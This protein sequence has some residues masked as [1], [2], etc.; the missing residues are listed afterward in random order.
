MR[1]SINARAS[2]A[3]GIYVGGPRIGNPD[4]GLFY[5]LGTTRAAAP[6]RASAPGYSKDATH[7]SRP[8]LRVRDADRLPHGGGHGMWPDVSAALPIDPLLPEI[9]SVLARTNRLVLRAEPGAGKTTRVPGALLD[10][11]VAGRR[12]VAVVEPRR[13][14]A[15][16]SAEFV[17]RAR[18]TTVGGDVGYRVRFARRGGPGTRLWFLTD[19]VFGRDL[20]RDPFLE[21]VGVVV[22]DEFHE[23]HLQSDLALAVVRELQETVRPD[24]RLVVMSATLET[25]A[26][27]RYLGGC[28]VITSEGRPHPVAIH[29]DEGG[30][31]HTLADRVA[32]AVRGALEQ[33]GDVLVFLPG[34]AEIRRAAAAL[35]PIAATARV[36][37]LVLHGD[38]PLDEQ[39]RA[40]RVGPRRRVV[41]ATNVAETALTVEGVATVVDSGLARTLRFDARTGLDHLRLGSI[42]RSAAT[43]RAGR[44]GRLG[45]GGCIRLWTRAEE[46]GRRE[47]EAPEI[48]RVDLARTLLELAAWGLR[49]VTRLGWLDPPPAPALARAGELLLELGALDATGAPTETGRRML[50]HPVAPRLARMLV[51]AEDDGVAADGALLAALAAER[52]VLRA[53]RAFGGG[54]DDRP[55]GPSDLLARM[56]LFEE[57]ARVGFG[58]Q[59]CLRLGLDPGAVRA[60][61]R[62]RRQ[63][64]RGAAPRATVGPDD[65]A[66]LARL[67]RCVL[68]GFPDRV[69]RRREPGSPRAVMAGGTGVTLAPESVVRAAELFVAVAVEGGSRGAESRV[70]IASAVERGWLDQ[71][72]PGSV[73][74]ER[75]VS[76]DGERGRV[77]AR[78]TVRYRDVTLDEAVRGDVTREEV[79]R[80]LAEAAERDARGLLGPRP[81]VDALV[82]R[83][84]FLSRAMPELGL[85][86]DVES[87]VRAAATALASAAASLDALRQADVPGAIAGLLTHRQRSAVDR[88][89]PSHWTLPS[90]RRVPVAYERDRAPSARGRIQEM[91]G[92]AATPRL[93]GGRVPLVLALLAPNQRPVQ[94]TDDLASFWRTTYAQVRAELRGRYPRHVW[95]DDPMTATPTSRARRR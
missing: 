81:D 92:L 95:P 75:T 20:V 43:Q 5:K 67:L 16:A 9:A 66:S 42:S 54:R 65:P 71:V 45:P 33:D 39:A 44:A 90:G 27:A 41:L 11:G 6:R 91:F 61:E 34:A 48:L 79:A 40:L 29:Y 32:T 4:A 3:S 93:G 68:A 28:P 2:R 1:R 21:E 58:Q 36:D 87:L 49:D 89:A 35:A 50:G 26:L 25:D 57:A 59:A 73:T 10:A 8:L 37:V 60:V 53:G 18:G 55:P 70:R 69:C 47:H 51:Q 24:L 94:I 56:E 22:L 15:R 38:Q 78:T 19:G 82:A 85:P 14:A 84:Q 72:F 17:A 76:L 80:V 7:A 12:Q 31:G 46:A 83:L 23:R 88:E 63:L 77:V 74:S 62:A 30:E 86:V 64:A 52:D 13:I